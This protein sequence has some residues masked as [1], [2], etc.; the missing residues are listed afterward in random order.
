MGGN[1]SLSIAERSAAGFSLAKESTRYLAPQGHSVI[2]GGN[3]VR[4]DHYPDRDLHDN[5]GSR[6]ADPV[7][8]EP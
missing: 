3:A 1:Q 4:Y 2:F 8:L 7:L 5:G 6:A